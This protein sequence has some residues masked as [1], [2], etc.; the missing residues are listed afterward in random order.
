M[1]RKG[2]TLIELLVVIA[3]IA[4]LAAILMPVFAQAR[5]KA[6]QASCLSNMKQ[7]GLG[8]YMY[9]QDHDETL[10][11]SQ[12]WF[13]GFPTTQRPHLKWYHVIQPYVKNEQLTVCPSDPDAASKPRLSGTFRLN[14]QVSYGWN[15][16]HMPYRYPGPAETWTPTQWSFSMAAYSRPA[17][18]MVFAD[19]DLRDKR[20]PQCGN[21]NK[22]YQY[23]YCPFDWWQ[24]PPNGTP[25]GPLVQT[26]V[27]GNISDRHN[28]GASVV[29]MDGHAK[30]LSISK[31][32]NRTP[33]T[34]ELWGHG[35]GGALLQ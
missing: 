31:L 14:E 5:E 25:C 6:R 16:P 26:T 17:N 30:W 18:V 28:S 19:S 7:L 34:Q 35:V 11:A 10:A 33:E 20:A 9:V 2:F 12:Y 4:I 24:N 21:A 15:Y 32:Y 27:Y 23:V 3:I 22:F 1:L 29:F 8:Y 13:P